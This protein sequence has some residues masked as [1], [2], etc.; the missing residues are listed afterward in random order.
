[1]RRRIRVQT[2]LFGLVVA[3]AGSVTA[4]R[5]AVAQTTP[6]RGQQI[7]WVQPRWVNPPTFRG[8][9]AAD[10]FSG[11]ATRRPPTRPNYPGGQRGYWHNPYNN[12]RD[13]NVYRPSQSRY[14][15]VD[16]RRVSR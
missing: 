9:R 7:P 5:P 2:A 4:A 15:W 13:N 16:R 1:M 12:R 6:R 3:A 11:T 10:P 14:I 8:V